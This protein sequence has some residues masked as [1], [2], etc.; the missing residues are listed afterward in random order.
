MMTFNLYLRSSKAAHSVMGYK[1]DRTEVPKKAVF[2]F[3]FIT[4]EELKSA[5]FDAVIVGSGAG[6]GVVAKELSEAGLKVLVVERGKHVEH[7]EEPLTEGEAIEELYDKACF[8][9]TA[10]GG[11]AI[12]EGSCFGGGTTVNWAASLQVR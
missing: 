5:K 2:R 7:E 1:P 4:E 11:C 3:D 12:I 9:Q 8:L 6:G 10:N